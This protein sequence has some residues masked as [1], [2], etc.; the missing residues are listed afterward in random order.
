M[1]GFNLLTR[2]LY[3]VAKTEILKLDIKLFSCLP[4]YKVHKKLLVKKIL[5]D[6]IWVSYKMK[7]KY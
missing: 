3:L 6:L 7:L 5:N 1:T 4:S 2:I